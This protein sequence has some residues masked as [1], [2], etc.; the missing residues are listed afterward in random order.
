[1]KITAEMLF[2]MLAKKHA[3]QLEHIKIPGR[4]IQK[5]LPWQDMASPDEN[6][7]YLLKNQ[8]ELNNIT[9]DKPDFFLLCSPCS[10]QL[11]EFTQ[12][13]TF[14]V[15]AQKSDP[16]V[17]HIELLELCNDLMRWDARF[18][19]AILHKKDAKTIL[20]WGQELLDYEYVVIDSNM[21]HLYATPH[22]SEYIGERTGSVSP[23][24]VHNLMMQPAFHAV[25]N[26]KKSF[27][28]FDENTNFHTLCGNLFLDQHYFA[29]IV[30]YISKK[31]STVSEGV[32]EIFELF[33]SHAEELV[34]YS[35]APVSR[36]SNDELHNLFRTL[37]A[38][39]KPSPAFCTSVLE[40]NGWQQHHHYA[41]LKLKFFED[42]GWS[43]QLAT[44]LPYLARELE[45]EWMNSC[46]VMEESAILWLINL[47]LSG[48]DINWHAFHQH[49]AFFVRDHVCNAGISSRFEDFSLIPYAVLEADAA[50]R[51]GQQKQPYFWYYLFDDYRLTYMLEKAREELPASML[52]HPAIQQLRTYD[53]AN[54]TELA[55]T[56]Q[57][58]LQC[59]LNMTAAAER[60]YIHRTTFCRRMNHIRKLTGLDMNDQDTILTLLLSY[61]LM[62]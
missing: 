3:L 27:Y 50:L 29:R 4:P 5:I 35:I 52:C 9:G 24:N 56:L 42:T 18:S 51:I 32:R 1:M 37:I 45:W 25:A 40:K 15:V 22:Y 33:V 30:M 62:C 58:Y 48:S 17:L 13:S 38:N 6:C 39:K 34:K 49:L 47:S 23:D 12:Q 20:S 55:K 31:E 57:A 46:A 60:L 21:Q 59:N 61:R 2:C 44:A 41:V 36:H 16:V 28:Y 43:P 7:L 11:S 14:A 8:D 10:D 54:N 26:L 53:H 19:E